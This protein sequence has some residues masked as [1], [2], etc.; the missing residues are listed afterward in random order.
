MEI[1]ENAN[2]ATGRRYPSLLD[3]LAEAYFAVGRTD[4]AIATAIEARDLARQVN[5]PEL[6]REIDRKLQRYRAGGADSPG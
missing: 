1:A 2:Q 6:A 4:E 5:A 3:V